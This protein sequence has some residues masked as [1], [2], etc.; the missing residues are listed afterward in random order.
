MG[1]GSVAHC[2]VNVKGNRACGDDIVSSVWCY[3]ARRR[4][5][6]PI[7]ERAGMARRTALKSAA[8]SFCDLGFPRLLF[9]WLCST[10][11]TGSS[12]RDAMTLGLPY[13]N[14]AIISR[15]ERLS[16]GCGALATTISW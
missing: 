1:M 13:P 3:E 10:Y 9:G 12:A 8:K 7:P 11:L 4:A 6:D 16:Y 5:R 14:G 15:A 2:F